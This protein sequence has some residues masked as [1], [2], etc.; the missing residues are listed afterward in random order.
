MRAPVPL[1]QNWMV[2]FTLDP[3]MSRILFGLVLL[4]ISF[5]FSAQNRDAANGMLKYIVYDFD[6]LH[7]GQNNLPDGDYY[8]GDLSFA[9]TAN[10]LAA[11]DVIGDRS[12]KLSL[13]WQSGAGEFGKATM[14]FL[15]LNPSTDKLNFYIYNPVMN[16]GAANVQV[17]ITE[18]DN[19]NN[20]YE[21]TSD[22]KWTYTLSIP[23][24]GA[25]QLMS[26]P[27]SSLQDGNSG[28]NGS[29]DAAYTGAGGM[30][31]SVGLVFNKPGSA[32]VNDEYYLDMLCFSDG[33]LPVGSSILELPDGGGKG[34][35][36]GALTS[37][38]QPDKT[39]AEVQAYL[40][41]GKKLTYVNWFVFYSSSGT[42]ADMYPGAEVQNLLDEGYQPVITWE[43]MYEDYPRLD[44]V[45]PR[46]SKILDGSF[47]GYIDA[48]AAKIKS[49]SGTVIMRIF[50][51]FEGDWYSWS[52]SQNGNDPAKYKAA[53]QHV[54]NR[55]RA[56]GAS[57]VRWMWCLNAEPKPYV[58]YNWVVD[59]YPGDN[60]VDIV[61]TDIYNHPDLGTPDWKSFRYT[62]SETYYYLA[63]YFPGKPLYVCEVG[64]RER[65]N[66]E[67]GASQSKGDWLCRMNNDLKAY[68]PKTE[69]LIFFSVQ[70]EH[71]W[72]INSSEAAKQSF[73]SCF[74][75]DAF[76]GQPVGVDFEEGQIS[77]NA[78]PNPFNDRINLLVAGLPDTGKNLRFRLFDL[79]GRLIMNIE[80]KTLPTM[81]EPSPALPD[82][83][84]I[85]ELSNGAIMKRQ[86]LVK[87]LNR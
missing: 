42:T 16:S 70:K 23:E 76:Y 61:A 84:Y 58:K 48:F 24:S 63:K 39:P 41:A 30:L 77:F 3:L 81:V 32:S 80:G 69:A 9:V 19:G 60:Y 33:D 83:L 12:L 57:N 47:D 52:L 26:V 1:A 37:N 44:P 22:D 54:V 82:G 40:P 18:D 14:R 73:I 15:E 78:Y 56:A 45:Q 38:A 85:A 86:K 53:F 17:I 59:A 35:A 20:V 50:H 66:S 72:R 87:G 27:L 21:E 10:P 11:S 5:F 43:M 31:F 51:E 8:N 71:D 4:F 49:Y 62:M 28:G 34:C 36:L 29:F 79:D 64:C 6:G 68:F 65:N 46:L 55:F 2:H 75:N 67:A 74:W 25:W 13:S 7:T